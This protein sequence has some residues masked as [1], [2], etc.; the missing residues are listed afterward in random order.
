MAR[1]IPATL[2]PDAQDDSSADDGFQI[3]DGED[4][5]LPGDDEANGDGADDA[6]QE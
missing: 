5:P 6:D 3:N 2:T 4:T 1:P